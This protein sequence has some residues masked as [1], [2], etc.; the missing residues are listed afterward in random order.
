MGN[1]FDTPPGLDGT[2]RDSCTVCGT[3]TDTGVT[4]R[5]SA[6][7]CIAGLVVLGVPLK[8]A[9]GTFQ[10]GLGNDPRSLERPDADV[11]VTFLVCKACA[12]PT[13]FREALAPV[14]EKKRPTMTEPP[15]AS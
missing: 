10:V 2:Y 4:F 6:E 15:D 12:D 7:W 14:F 13:P 9:I 3:G 1:P 11:T 5:G 8:Q